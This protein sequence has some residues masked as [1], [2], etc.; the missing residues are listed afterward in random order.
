MKKGG[1]AKSL[2]HPLFWQIAFTELIQS[3]EM[4]LSNFFLK[5]ARNDHELNYLIWDLSSM[6]E[7]Q[8][9]LALVVK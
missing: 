8:D 3:K 9:K 4:L 6:K 2:R 5:N 7:L 1:A